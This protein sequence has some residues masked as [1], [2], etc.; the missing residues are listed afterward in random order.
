MIILLVLNWLVQADV[1]ARDINLY[2]KFLKW[3]I[4]LHNYK[5]LDYCMI[6]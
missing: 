5:E 1:S 4:L 3:M 2:L 6:Y